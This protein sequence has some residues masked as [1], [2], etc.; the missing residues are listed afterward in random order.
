MT[1]FAAVAGGGTSGHV[2]PALAI[3]DALVEREHDRSHILYV[4][5]L[6]GVETT[7]VPPT[8]TP[9]V[10]FD[11]VGLRR[12]LT[13]WRHNFRFVPKL[14]RARRRAIEMFRADR[15]RVVVSVGGYASLPAVLAAR[16]LKIPIVV[17]SYDRRPGRSS[18]ITSRFASVVATAFPE[19]DLRRAVHTGAP[20]R[21]EIR[22]LDRRTARDEARRCLDLPLDRFVVVVVGGSLGSGALNDAVEVL[23][24][25]CRDDSDLAVFQVAGDR[26][27][28]VVQERMR[29]ILTSDT[30]IVLR[31]VG[32]HSQMEDLYAAADVVVGRGGAGTIAEIA[33]VGVP[34]ILVP[35]S[36][37]ADDHQTENVRWLTD[38][39][40][41][42]SLSDDSV[43]DRLPSVINDLRADPRRLAEMGH[44]AYGLGDANRRAAVADLVITT[45]AGRSPG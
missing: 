37:A 12:S 30:R 32:Y 40:A 21:A 39:G 6:R 9:H 35:W 5:A 36:G 29:Q 24:R 13:A 14:L 7:L 8:G 22:R 34:S 42:V 41:A 38:A 17:V 26:F 15:P 3:I 25:Q 33:T 23:V 31:V 20:V 19:T 11:V 18:R 16:S 2:V 45:A 44:A 43:V 27:V 4:G 10:F 1:V 28:E